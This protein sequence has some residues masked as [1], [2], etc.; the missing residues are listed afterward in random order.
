M[1]INEVLHFTILLFCHLFEEFMGFEAFKIEKYKK[2]NKTAV[3]WNPQRLMSF[4][5]I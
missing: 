3:Y 2:I 4:R 5:N 1:C